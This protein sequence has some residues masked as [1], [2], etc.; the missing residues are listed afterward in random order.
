[1]KKNSLV[2]LAVLAASGA[3]F[4]QSSVTVYGIADVFLAATSGTGV[5]SQTLLNSGGVSASRWGLKG[6]E[7]L[8]GGLKANF[9]LEQGFAI[10]SGASST[11]GAAFARYSYVGLSGGFGEIKLGHVGTAADDIG[12][13]SNSAFDSALSAQNGVWKSTGF[14]STPNNNIYYA[15][16][17]MG[18]FS[19]AASYGL[20]EDKAAATATSNGDASSVTS[21]NVQYAAGPLFAAFGYQSDKPQGGAASTD[22]T[23]L[24]ANYDFGVAKLLA[25]YGRKAAP[26]S[27]DTTDWEL[28]ADF[29][30][31]AA[32]TLSGGFARSSDNAAAGNA[33]RTGYGFAAAY[34]LSKRTTAYG[35]FNSNTT[36][37]AGTD[38]DARTLAVGVKHTF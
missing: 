38:T 32:L 26:N 1:M 13:A 34:S 37:V 5:Q 25:G 28:G 20:G 3:S 10:D 23:L 12:G 21:L 19:A 24:R 9:L 36:S 16:P 8:G 2:A 29:P 11:A 7:D 6:T 22:Y 4:A 27:A 17:T 35:G 30:M 14:N 33:T 18:G 31:S 15:S